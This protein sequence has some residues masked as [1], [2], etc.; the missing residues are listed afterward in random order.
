MKKEIIEWIVANRCNCYRHTCAKSFY[1]LLIQSKGASMHP[2]FENREKVI[3]SRIAKTLDHIDTGDVVIFHANNAKQ[4]MISDL[5][6][7]QVIQ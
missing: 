3:V 5:L 1:L 2:T 6:V 7:N 4:I